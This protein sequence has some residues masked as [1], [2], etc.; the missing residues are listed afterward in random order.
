MNSN[1]EVQAK[2]NLPR[3][4]IAAMIMLTRTEGKGYLGL[5]FGT[6]AHHHHSGGAWESGVES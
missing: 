4:F 3:C 1:V 5:W 6:K 2:I